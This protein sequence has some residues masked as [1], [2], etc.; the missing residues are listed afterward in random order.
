MYTVINKISK[1]CLSSFEVKG[2]AEIY[3]NTSAEP[4]NLEIIETELPL[5]G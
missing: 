3:I 4:W 1:E 5:E 2:H